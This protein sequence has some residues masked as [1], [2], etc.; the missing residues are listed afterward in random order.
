MEPNRNEQFI[1][2]LFESFPFFLDQ[3]W[4][5]VGLPPPAM[6]QVDIAAWLQ[7]GPK[8]RGIRSFRGA[9]KTW[10]TIAYAAW[11]LFRNPKHERITVVSKSESHSKDSLHLL[12]KWI[13]NVPFLQHLQ[14]RA[15]RNQR[16]SA[17]K[18]DVGP[19]VPDRTPSFAVYGIGGQLTGGRST[20][21]IGDDVE[22][23]QNTLT[24]EMRVRLRED[25]KEFDNMIVPGADIIYLG[26][27]HHEDTLYAK[28]A[29]DGWAFQSWPDR[30]P[31]LLGPRDDIP[32][33]L[34]PP[35]RARLESGEKQAGDIMWPER[36]T[37]EELL[38]REASEGRSVYARQ[39]RL[40][41]GLDNA[42]LYPLRLSDLIV[43]PVLRDKA[44]LT[45]A[46]G[47]TN[48]RGG[49]TRIQDIPSLGLGQ[50]GFFAPIFF[51]ANW[52]AY[53][54]THMWIDP[55]GRGSDE[56]G[57]AIVS[58]ANG[59][60]YAHVV[61]GLPGGY[62]PDTLTTLASEAR[63]Y[64]AGD[65]FIE[66][67]FGSGMFEPLIAPYLQ[68]L[69]RT[70]DDQKA[71]SSDEYTWRC[72]TQT[73]HSTGQKE[74]RIISALEPV[75]NQHRLVVS[76]QVAENQTLQRQITRLTKQRQCLDHDDQVEALAMCVRSWQDTL[77]IDPE[78]AAADTR[79]RWLEEQIKA[80][81]RLAGSPGGFQEASWIQ[82]V[83]V[84]V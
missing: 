48:D 69:W 5:A 54:G 81:Q 80:H 78:Q 65:I 51:D 52:V 50:D 59:Y 38:A 71:Q 55:G 22:T 18:F 56:V 24:L 72:S 46:W 1:A 8:R 45:I 3:L 17:T 75:L 76:R 62:G 61:G 39:Y 67:Q 29:T 30:Y 11:R 82:R 41:R 79:D 6:H 53:T 84:V 14:P 26:T 2:Q 13:D 4:A 47:Q 32:P 74:I 20:C 58:M 73:I 37:S 10:E 57:Y 70:A 83:P 31:D 16:D 64:R 34:A 25:V 19:A 63:A 27:D 60:L 40:V 33:D 49:T 28:L 21:I 36:F 23:S 43:F 42:N 66:D 9:S 35:A 7:H 68:R 15:K 12:R 77:H 44:P